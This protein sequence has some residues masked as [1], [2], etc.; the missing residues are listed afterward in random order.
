MYETFRE[1]FLSQTHEWTFVSKSM[2]LLFS[3]ICTLGLSSKCKSKATSAFF[4]KRK[5]ASE[6]NERFVG[7]DPSLNNL[8][9]MIY[10]LDK[11]LPVVSSYGAVCKDIDIKSD[12]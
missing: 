2:C 5:N 11:S 12:L 10:P 7:T 6:H 3:C 8:S 4:C 9:K 1:Y